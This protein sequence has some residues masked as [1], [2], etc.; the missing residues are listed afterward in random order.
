[1]NV[2]VHQRIVTVKTR[3]RR[4]CAPWHVRPVQSALATTNAARRAATA[5][6]VAPAAHGA[7]RDRA[8]RGGAPRGDQ[9]LRL[10]RRPPHRAVLSSCAALASLCVILPLHV[11][12]LL[13]PPALP[14]LP[15]LP[16]PRRSSSS[17]NHGASTCPRCCCAAYAAVG[18]HR[19]LQTQAAPATRM[20]L[21]YRTPKPQPHV[22]QLVPL[23]STRDDATSSASCCDATPLSA[24]STLTGS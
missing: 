2:H 24:A 7:R 18:A 5:A 12:P 1:M 10:L 8:R 16:L 15:P 11:L 14:S 4:V 22:A 23:H 17:F 13:L 20:T 6:R 21:A 9:R 3:T 19:L